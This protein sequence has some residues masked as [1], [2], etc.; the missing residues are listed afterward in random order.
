M[1][2]LIIRTNKKQLEFKHIL[3]CKIGNVSCLK[4]KKKIFLNQTS[5][6]T[7]LEIAESFFKHCIFVM[8]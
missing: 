5:F 2:V 6:T 1:S 7:N 4:K 8:F 3:K